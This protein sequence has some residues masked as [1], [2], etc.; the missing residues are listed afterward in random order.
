VA[1]RALSEYVDASTSSLVPSHGRWCGGY[2]CIGRQAKVIPVPPFTIPP[3][4][5]QVAVRA[6]SK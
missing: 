1:V 2:L 3:V 5:D 4:L 6:L